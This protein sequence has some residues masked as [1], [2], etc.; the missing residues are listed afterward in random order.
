[1]QTYWVPGVNNTGR[2]G[3]WAFQEFQVVYTMESEFKQR[4]E[5]LF[6]QMIAAACSENALAK[7]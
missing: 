4:V 7:A 3:R 1:M 6:Q 2:F 5:G